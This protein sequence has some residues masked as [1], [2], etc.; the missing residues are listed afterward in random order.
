MPL[1]SYSHNSLLR[2][3]NRA[4]K[5]LG[6]SVTLYEGTRHSLASQAVNRGV[7]LNLI[8]EMLVH[9]EEK[10]T[11][12]YSHIEADTLKVVLHQKPE[13][14]AEIIEMNRENQ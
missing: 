11:R 12:R 13:K 5:S 6:L 3:W 14:K 7:P 1:F 2:A 8:G 4:I 10:S 9:T